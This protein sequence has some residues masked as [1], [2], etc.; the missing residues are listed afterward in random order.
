MTTKHILLTGVTGYIGGSIAKK[1]LNSGYQVLGL[2]RDASKV[3]AIKKMGIQPLLGSLDD[4]TGL[5]KAAQSVDVVINAASSDHRAAV[6]TFLSA[7]KGSGK[8]FIH[9][10]GSSVVGDDARGEYASE[11]IFADDTPF[12]PMDIRQARVKM[13]NDIRI[14]GVQ[15][16]MRTMVI[17]P[18]MI[19]GDP[20]GLPETRT[21]QLPKLIQKSKEKRSGVYIGKGVNIWSHVHINDLVELYDLAV[22]KGPSAAMFFAENGETSFIEIAKT[23]S[24]GLGFGG[25]VSCWR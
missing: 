12:V 15:D 24:K 21:D 6:D 8:T 7:L 5:S 20:L 18:P 13:N 9:T 16:G 17:T 25:N 19:Y 1:M 3:D 10:S 4:A 14:A 2:V 22:K 11:Q 23:I